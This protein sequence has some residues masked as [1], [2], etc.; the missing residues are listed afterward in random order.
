VT[1]VHGS[2]EWPILNAAQPDRLH[3]LRIPRHLA[4]CSTR[5]IVDGL[6]YV[7][8]TGCQWASMPKDLPP[9]STVNG[10]FCRWNHDGTLDRIH[11]A[12]Y[13]RCRETVG[14]NS[15]PTAAIIPSR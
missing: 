9:R 7:L 4:T 13:V 14:R 2:S 10:Y 1:Q 11:H 6:M 3:C 8:G 5:E 15:S 12:L